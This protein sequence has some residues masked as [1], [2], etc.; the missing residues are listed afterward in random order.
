MISLVTFSP[1][2]SVLLSIPSAHQPITF[3]RFLVAFSNIFRHP[4]PLS[5]EGHFLTTTPTSFTKEI[6]FAFLKNSN[7]F[8]AKRMN[9]EKALTIDSDSFSMSEEGSARK[10]H[11]DIEDDGLSST[12]QDFDGNSEEEIVIAADETRWIKWS[13]YLVGFVLILGTTLTAYGAYNFTSSKQEDA[14]TSQVC[15]LLLFVHCSVSHS[16]TCKTRMISPSS[17]S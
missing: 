17:L 2:K 8:Q 3:L 7:D 5:L 11:D 15:A 12:A 6:E 4:A 14:F 10:P 16:F 1:R 13:K 9:E